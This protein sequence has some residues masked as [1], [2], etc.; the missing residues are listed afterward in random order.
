MIQFN[1]I[2]PIRL[3]FN[4]NKYLPFIFFLALFF[5][6]ISIYK[7]FGSP[8]DDFMNRQRGIVTLNYVGK[9]FDINF[10]TQDS[11]LKLPAKVDQLA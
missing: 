6:G 4:G 5:L 3:F 7:D 10:I 1:K 11:I 2:L 9:I 8:I